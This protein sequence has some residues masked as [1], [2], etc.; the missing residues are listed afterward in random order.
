V[1]PVEVGRGGSGGKGGHEFVLSTLDYRHECQWNLANNCRGAQRLAFVDL[2]SRSGEFLDCKITLHARDFASAG[3]NELTREVLLGPK[4]TRRLALGDVG[5]T[6]DKKATDVACTPVA[7]LAKNAAAGKCRAKLTENINAENFYPRSAKDRGVEG[8]AV[9]RYYVPASG[10][11]PIDAEIA[12]SSGDA[13][14][15]DAALATVRS[16][17]FAKDCAYGLSTIRIAF[18][19]AD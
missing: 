4:A 9:V 10:A 18:K 17:K 6:P 12:T 1:Q 13:E 19:L 8:S 5:D 14:L 15:D 3:T 16:G 11:M 7:D 2:T